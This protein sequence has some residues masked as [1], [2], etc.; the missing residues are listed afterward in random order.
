METEE[1]SMKRFRNLVIL[2][3]V[4]FVVILGIVLTKTI[5][6]HQDS[7]KTVDKEILAVS[8]DDL[9]GVEWTNNEATIAFVQEDGVW[10]DSEDAAFP[11]NQDQIGEFLDQFASVHASFIIS[12]VADFDQYG[13]ASPSASITFTTAEGT[14]TMSFGDYSVMDSKRYVTLGDEYVYLIDTDLMEAAETERDEF[15]QHD[16]IPTFT[17]LDTFT[18]SGANELSI[19]YTEED[20]YE[21]SGVYYY[22]LKE[23]D[24]Y[25]ALEGSEVRSLIAVLTGLDLTDYVTYTASADDLSEYGLDNPAITVVISGRENSTEDD[26]TSVTVYVGAVATSETDDDGN[27]LYNAYVRVGDS[28]IVY[29]AD[30]DVYTDLRDADYN[31]LRPVN[32][33]VADWD[34]VTALTAVVGEETYEFTQG[35]NED[36]ES[37]VLYNDCEVSVSSIETALDA[38]EV[39]QFQDY[40]TPGSELECSITLSTTLEDYPTLTV[41]LYT[42]DGDSC[43]AVMNGENLG[44]V[45]R[46][47]MVTLREAILTEILN[48]K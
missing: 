32:V 39:T 18:V 43:F 25:L 26:I 24:N 12:D 1:K 16:D 2:L 29:A 4:F 41:E 10:K 9:T 44:L 11:V 38:L 47:Q 42:C 31:S 13:L 14:T 17:T 40:K 27:T 8:V 23:N 46:S 20:T 36:G 33:I 45:S 3:A 48:A 28:E 22:F 19:L 6:R 30:S 7:L 35:E 37:V 15:M 5:T 21:Y 34:T